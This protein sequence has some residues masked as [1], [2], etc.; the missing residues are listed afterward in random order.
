MIATFTHSAIKKIAQLSIG[1]A[2][3]T[4]TSLSA[5]PLT[6]AQAIDMFKPLRFYGL[7]SIPQDVDGS[8]VLGVHTLSS[9]GADLRSETL[10]PPFVLSP[11]RQTDGMI[12]QLYSLLPKSLTDTT[13]FAVADRFS[14]NPE[15]YLPYLKSRQKFVIAGSFMGIGSTATRA[16]YDTSWAKDQHIRELAQLEAMLALAG[17]LNL[18]V[19]NVT[20]AM[21]DS[22][23]AIGGA[24]RLEMQ[25]KMNAL[26]VSYGYPAL[27]GTLSW[28]ADETIAMAM[29][30]LL[31]SK[32]I[33]IQYA[34]PSATQWY[35]SQNTAQRITTEKLPSLGLVQTASSTF[36]IDLAVF[37]RRVG[38]AN[39]DYQANDSAQTTLDINFASRF[40]GYTAAQRNKLAIVDG[41]MFN[42]SW[43][44]MSLIRPNTDYL[45]YGGW[46]TFGN[47]MGLTLAVAKI[48]YNNPAAR[49]QMYLEAVAHDVFMGGYAEAQRGALFARLRNITTDWGHWS[50]W[51]TQAHTNDSFWV[52]NDFVNLRMK[53]YYGANLGNKTFRFSPQIWRIF[54]A[55]VRMTPA[56]AA[57]PVGVYRTSPSFM[58]PQNGVFPKLG[59]AELIPTP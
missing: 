4:T 36:D 15:A 51:K 35:D 24:V 5:T 59:L 3:A 40:S 44:S 9:T 11:R 27:Q 50:G 2:M 39:N 1:L 32:T 14:Q 58:N 22:S 55:D 54:E 26:L 13:A 49:K 46:G 21:G 20:Y 30:K 17:A 37:T 42:G 12:R 28:G 8:N 6:E 38:G 31:P 23:G 47:K 7:K 57:L 18:T 45:A 52:I 33:R 56:D 29:A 34:N 16:A 48:V 41:R 10:Y 43:D 19:T 25:G 53:A